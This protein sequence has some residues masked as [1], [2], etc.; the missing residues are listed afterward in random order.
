MDPTD[1]GGRPP[2]PERPPPGPAWPPPPPPVSWPGQPPGSAPP[3]QPGWGPPP[4]PPP[5]PPGWGPPPPPSPPTRR[6]VGWILAGLAGLLIVALVATV[7]AVRPRVQDGSAPPAR[8]VGQRPATKVPTDP[9]AELPRL[10]A[11]RAKALLAGDRAAF[12]AT[13]DRRQRSWYRKQ[14]TLFERMRTAPFSAFAYRVLDQRADTR[15]RRRYRAEQVEVARVQARYRFRGQDASP[16][17]ARYSYTFA[18]TRSGWRIAG[19]GDDRFRGRDDVEIWDSGPVRT[20]R[21]ARTLIV[22]HPGQEVLARRLLR[23]ADKSYGQVGA[24]WTGRWERKAVILV[25]HD[26]REAERLVGARDLSRVAAVASSSVESGAAERVLGNRIVVNTAN[27]SGYNELNLQILITHEMTHVATRTLGDGVPL[28]LVEG[29]ADWAALKPLGYPFRVTRPAL[30]RLGSRFDGALPRDAEFRG[31]QAAVAYDEGS[32]FC[33][34]VAETAGPAKL[35]ALYRQFAGS[36]PPTSAQLDR[37]FRRALG[38]SRRTA[39]GRWAAWV[40]AQL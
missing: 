1:Q 15:L 22:H 16:V 25:P 23:I 17:L 29:F 14:A 30:A 9:R 38:I 24:A 26:E 34:W 11:K 5:G 12:L 33:L 7:L 37:G 8:A 27:V 2:L 21:S 13:V 3:G 18:L 19:D 20:V 36:D 39:E 10:L 31:P 28:L 40:R 4:G 6:R 35:Q 32:A